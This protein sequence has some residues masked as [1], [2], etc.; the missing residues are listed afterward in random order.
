[1]K[2]IRVLLVDDQPLFR[3]GLRT[4]LS[5]QPGLE[6]VGE[7]AHGIEAVQRVK[8]LHP[9]VVLMD[10]RM[11]VLNGV[12]AT[13]RVRTAAPDCRVLVLTTFDDDEEVFEALRAGAV[14]YLLKDAPAKE[15][16][17]AIRAVARGESFLQPSIAAKVLAEFNRLS[18]GRPALPPELAKPLSDREIE[19]LRH[20]AQ[21]RS[22]KEIGAVL[23]LAEGTVK[24]HMTNILGKLGVQ[25]RTQAALKGRELGLF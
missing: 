22:N 13:R 12:E 24:N 1:M 25:D 15:L 8:T 17:E 2:P 10:L 4:L 9:E 16:A 19:V 5:V 11:P 14:G 6:V 20:L 18:R 7:A 21:G 23:N 3:E